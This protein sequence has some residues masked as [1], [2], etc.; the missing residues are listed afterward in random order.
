MIF[1]H[2]LWIFT[3]LT[4]R[5]ILGRRGHM[6][7]G[8]SGDGGLTPRPIPPGGKIELAPFPPLIVVEGGSI[9]VPKVKEVA[10]NIPAGVAERKKIQ[11]LKAVKLKILLEND[12]QIS[13]TILRGE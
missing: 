5:P 6:N 13:G 4:S 3:N 2:F 10:P 12:S 8:C 11:K 7:R 9:L 1:V